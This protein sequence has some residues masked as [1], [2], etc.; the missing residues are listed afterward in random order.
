[1]KKYIPLLILVTTLAKISFAQQWYPSSTLMYGRD[2][3]SIQIFN[4]TNIYLAGGSDPMG[5]TLYS[6]NDCGLS[7][8][9]LA[10]YYA[11]W[12]RSSAFTNLLT[13]V[14]VGESGTLV[15][16]TT[17]GSSWNG[18]NVPLTADFNQVIYTDSQTLFVVGGNR[19]ND[20]L[21]VILKSTDG[22][23]NWNAV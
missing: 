19:W 12:F 6:S 9:I 13:G 5:R 22:G 8:G 18:A 7:W 16:T 1:M 10:D 17:G 4:R 21:Q 14:G 2:I 20:S 3:N 23:A 11:P 15:T